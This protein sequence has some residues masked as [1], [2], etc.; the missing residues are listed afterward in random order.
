[1]M[2]CN[3]NGGCPW[4]QRRPQNGRLYDFCTSGLRA[5]ECVGA[6]DNCYL[7]PAAFPRIHAEILGVRASTDVLRQSLALKARLDCSGYPKPWDFI[8]SRET[9][10]ERAAKAFEILAE[11]FQSDSADLSE[12]ELEWLDGAVST[13]QMFA[14]CAETRR[15]LCLDCQHEFATCKSNPLFGN[16]VGMDNVFMCD[17]F[18]RSYFKKG[19]S[20]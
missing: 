9:T 19:G 2:K 4:R 7:T 11:I 12:M 20:E 3:E 13:I 1:M 5:I 17:G 18:E 6:V 16:G 14:G 15:H 8:A 10:A